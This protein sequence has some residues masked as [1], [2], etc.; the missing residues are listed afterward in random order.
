MDHFEM[1]EKLRAKANVSYED[2]KRA[3]EAADWD[4]LDALVLL[5]GEGRIKPEAKEG[6]TTKKEPQPRREDGAQA[7]KGF[8][9]RLLE[10]VASLVNRG[11]RI[12]FEVRKHDKV[13]FSLPMT[14]MVLL[15]LFTFW[16]SLVLLVVGLFFGLRYSLKGAKAADAVNK[17]MDKAAQAAEN[18]RSGVAGSAHHDD[19]S[20][21]VE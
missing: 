3:L 9:R 2:A 10:A 20:G 17:A 12:D 6:F 21:T 4:L 8:F 11:N 15:L 19:A 7:A 5:E 18:I 1:V 14:A 13:V 16:F